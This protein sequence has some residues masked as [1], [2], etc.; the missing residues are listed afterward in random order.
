[1]TNP[2]KSIIRLPDGTRTRATDALTKAMGQLQAG[3]LQ[4]ANNL[5]SVI[6]QA[7]PKNA[8][9]LHLFGLCRMELGDPEQAQN[10]IRR[11]IRIV[12]TAAMFHANLGNILLKTGD[13]EGACQSLL[14]ACELQPD[15]LDACINLGTAYLQ[16]NRISKAR[17]AFEQALQL[18]PGHFLALAGLGDVSLACNAPLRAL[19]LFREMSPQHVD[20]PD[21][22]L[23]IGVALRKSGNEEGAIA[24]YRS[25]L[26]RYPDCTDMHHNLAL[27]L[28]GRGDYDEAR[29]HF[30]AVLKLVP[31][32]ATARHMLSALSGDNSVTAPAE[33]V[34]STFDYYADTFEDHLVSTLNYRTPQC[35]ARAIGIVGPDTVSTIL[36]LGCGTGLMAD[37]LKGYQRLVG[38]DLS[39]RMLE[40]AAARKAYTELVEADVDGY[41][42]DQP[43]ATFDLITSAD[44]FVYMGDLET[45]FIEVVR[46]LTLGGVF[47]FSVEA[48]LNEQGDYRLQPTGRYQHHIE[49]IRHM[50]RVAGLRER[51]LEKLSIREQQGKAVEGYVCVY[52]KDAKTGPDDLQV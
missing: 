50:A 33:Y 5:L 36:D 9:A 48:L 29:L 46:V 14:R 22:Q 24:H 18:S 45:T 34:R 13:P 32:D 28:Q 38:I 23:R 43:D 15:L 10:L 41:L 6:V 40:R 49:Y 35:I 47:A 4:Q 52:S 51:Y 12:P 27:I 19:E 30:E 37:S 20:A 1:M 16:L 31:D 8:D 44:V 25:A 17:A 42:Q 7:L 21:M 3:H 26:A 39:P 11:A 2:A